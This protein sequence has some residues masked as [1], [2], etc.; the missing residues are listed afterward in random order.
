VIRHIFPNGT[1]STISWHEERRFRWRYWYDFDFCNRCRRFW[2]FVH[3][4]KKVFE[5]GSVLTLAGSPTRGYLDGPPN[6][7]KFS[8][9]NGLLIDENSNMMSSTQLFGN[10][11]RWKCHNVFR[12]DF[13]GNPTFLRAVTFQLFQPRYLCRIRSG[14]LISLP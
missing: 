13:S 12:L 8:W 5:N 4:I 3:G 10:W 9:P 7:A 1:V 2:N 6:F 14:D 11:T